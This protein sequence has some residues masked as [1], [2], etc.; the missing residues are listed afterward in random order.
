MTRLEREKKDLRELWS[1]SRRTLVSNSFSPTSLVSQSSFHFQAIA[2]LVQSMRKI[3]EMS[4]S[5]LSKLS[6]C[7]SEWRRVKLGNNFTRVCPNSNNLK[8]K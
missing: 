7:D 2:K 5:G 3:P 6:T 1:C 4:K 8:R